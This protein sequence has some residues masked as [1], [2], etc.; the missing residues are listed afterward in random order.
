MAKRK[1]LEAYVADLENT[2]PQIKIKAL[3]KL[4]EI[5]AAASHAVP[6]IILL[7]NDGSWK[8]RAWAARSLGYIGPLAEAA[9]PYLIRALDD[10]MATVRSDA[11]LALGFILVSKQA[12]QYQSYR[13]L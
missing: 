9:V 4:G 10:K 1:T 12:Q 2:D 7:L 13:G 5:G 3:K 6:R 11:A 8:V